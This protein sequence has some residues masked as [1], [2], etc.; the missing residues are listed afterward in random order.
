MLAQSAISTSGTSVN[1]YIR[2]QILTE[3]ILKTNI[4]TY[5]AAIMYFD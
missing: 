4:P 1:F 2:M 5:K 3:T